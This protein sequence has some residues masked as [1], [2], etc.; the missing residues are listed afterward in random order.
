MLIGSFFVNVGGFFGGFRVSRYEGGE[1]IF[2]FI[3]LE[4]VF[5]FRGVVFFVLEWGL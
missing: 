5:G 4:N 3:C 2:F 1:G